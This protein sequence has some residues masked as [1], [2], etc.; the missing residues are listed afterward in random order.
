M[1]NNVVRPTPIILPSMFN[2]NHQTDDI[3]YE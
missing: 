3:L 2:A 1:I